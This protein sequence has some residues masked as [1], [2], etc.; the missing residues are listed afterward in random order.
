MED[1]LTFVTILEGKREEVAAE[2]ERLRQQ[3]NRLAGDV[4]VKEAQLRNLDDLLAFEQGG[5]VP[6]TVAAR[7]SKG[8]FLDEAYELVRETEAGL[9]YKDLLERLTERGIVVPGQDPAANLIAHLTRDERFV[10]TARGTYGLR[11]THRE[12]SATRRR[13]VRK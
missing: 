12:A 1:T 7:S 9:Y 3:M 8:H 11:G 2:L 10:R 6:E 5:A 13:R 4:S